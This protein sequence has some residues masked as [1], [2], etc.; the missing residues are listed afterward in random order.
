MEM[1]GDVAAF[2]R[3]D[4]L[5]E[6]GVEFAL[7][8]ALFESP[9]EFLWGAWA[10]NGLRDPAQFDY[11]DRMGSSSAGSPLRGADYPVKALYNLDNTCR[12][13]YGIPQTGS[14]PGECKIGIQPTL[15]SEPD[16]PNC[17]RI[18]VAWGPPS[19]ANP[20]CIRWETVCD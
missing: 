9:A 4:P 14:H 6:L 7:S 19:I 16:D 1:G 8:K 20:P 15:E 5:D 10:D 13:P 3:I 2:A 18:C 12:L 11:N 17:R